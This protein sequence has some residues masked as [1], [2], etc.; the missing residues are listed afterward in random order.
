MQLLLDNWRDVIATSS[1]A[2]DHTSTKI[3]EVQEHRV[4]LCTIYTSVTLTLT[5]YQNSQN[6]EMF[7]LIRLRTTSSGEECSIWH[8]LRDNSFLHPLSIWIVTSKHITQTIIITHTVH[9]TSARFLLS[10]TRSAVAFNNIIGK[11]LQRMETWTYYWMVENQSDLNL[12]M[13]NCL[14]SQNM[15]RKG[16][17]V[18][19]PKTLIISSLCNTFLEYSQISKWE[20][21]FRGLVHSDSQ[22]FD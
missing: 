3:T 5:P 14:K 1:S 22:P 4:Q 20:C 18:K 19:F 16:K 9:L 10:K 11:I 8:W 17:C 13:A 21:T 6:Q 7:H 2:L 12:N 15:Y